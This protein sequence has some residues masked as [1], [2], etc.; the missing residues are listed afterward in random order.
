MQTSLRY[1]RPSRNW[2]IG[3]GVRRFRSR[4]N[5]IVSRTLRAP[6][7]RATQRT[8][9]SAKPPCGGMPYLKAW[10]YPSR[11]SVACEHRHVV[12]V[13]VQPLSARDDFE[14]SE[15]TALGRRADDLRCGDLGEAEPVERRAEATQGGR[16]SSNWA[17]CLG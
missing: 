5:S 14:S 17:R 12:L 2:D 15:E 9:P 10:R 3:Y 4:G 11:G 7:S 1:A 6:T 13:S 8:R 16:A